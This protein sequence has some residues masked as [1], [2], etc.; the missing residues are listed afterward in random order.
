[1]KTILYLGTDPERFLRGREECRLIHYPVIR[2]VA[3]NK[4][5]IAI[6]TTTAHALSMYMRSPDHTAEEETQ[7]GLIALLKQCR[8]EDCYFL[9]PRS[10]LSRPVLLSFL[11]EQKIRCVA[12]DL[13]DT[14]MQRLEPVPDLNLIDEIVFTSPSTVQGFLHIFGQLPRHKQLHAIGPITQKALDDVI[15]PSL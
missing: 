1:M 6:G 8:T 11:Y 9:L 13:Y 5:L 10:S 15:N 12:F 14:C 3:R 4:I 7:E 2:V